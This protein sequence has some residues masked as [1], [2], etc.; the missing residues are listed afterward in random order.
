[1]EMWLQECPSC[2]F[3][4]RSIDQGH[5]IDRTNASS[6]EYRALVAS[7]FSSSVERRFLLQAALFAMRGEA[8]SAF[9]NALCAAWAADDRGTEQASAHRVKAAG[10][11][12]G[13]AGVS[14]DTRL[15][16]L[17]V[18]RRSSRWEAASGL[19]SELNSEE[20]EHPFDVI[21][22]FH[23]DK[24]AARDDGCYT[25]ARALADRRPPPPSSLDAAN[26]KILADYLRY[27]LEGE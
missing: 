14:I 24:I 27:R 5:E 13:R 10:H 20:L 7:S 1:M 22:G 12:Y 2:G 25:I 26:R 9:S 18:L 17:D 19:A 11:V 6:P 4:A 21:I 16:L 3:V 23:V 15:R 8:E